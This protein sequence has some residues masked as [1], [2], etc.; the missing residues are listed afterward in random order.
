[1]TYLDYLMVLNWKL[2]E[3]PYLEYVERYSIKLI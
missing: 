2:F 1:M 3:W